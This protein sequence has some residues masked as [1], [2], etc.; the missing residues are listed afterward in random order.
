MW[1]K[2]YEPDLFYR[3]MLKVSND[4][5]QRTLLRDTQRKGRKLTIRPPDP[6]HSG[7]TWGSKDGAL[8]AGFSQVPGI[9]DVMGQMIVDHRE[10]S[11]VEDWEDLLHVSG[12]GPKTME[13]IREFSEKGDDPFGALWLDRAIA[14][15]KGEIENGEL[16][17]PYPTHVSEDFPYER[18]PVDI[19]CIWL[20]TLFSR[21]ERD[22]F[23][24]N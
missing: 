1:F 2:F 4:D 7:V 9:G 20:G 3:E 22:L 24:F 10:E 8:L 18:G 6:K 21:N 5:R 17:L 16:D 19:E 12:I 13:T 15:V 23:E 14:A 11:G